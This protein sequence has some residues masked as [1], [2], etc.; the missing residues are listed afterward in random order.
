MTNQVDHP[1]S[2]ALETEPSTCKPHLVEFFLFIVQ[3][4]T[5]EAAFNQLPTS[6]TTQS[7]TEAPPRIE[8]STQVSSNE[9]RK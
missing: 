9:Y 1:L 3:S 7:S 5:A 4:Y 2:S 8:S 6:K